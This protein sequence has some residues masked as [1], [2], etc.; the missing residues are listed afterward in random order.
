M[1]QAPLLDYFA[2]ERQE[3]L[4]FIA[5]SI[6]AVMLSLWLLQRG[7]RY[8]GMLYPLLAI[9]AIQFVVGASVYLRTD[10]QVASLSALLRQQP[11]L[12]QQVERERMAVV[13]GNFRIYKAIEL[14]LLAAGVAMATVR[15][16]RPPWRAV[17]LGLVL[18]CLIMLMLDYF[19]EQ[20][21]LAYLAFINAL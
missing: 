12:F 18:Q 6:A 1:M 4:L 16:R 20:R 19:A 8:R 15:G 7:G 13:M 14:A 2:A 11:S 21:A 5:V 17:G 9:A 3:A 10:E